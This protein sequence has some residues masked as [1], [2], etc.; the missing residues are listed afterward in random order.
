MRAA[1]G[2]ARARE[3]YGISSFTSVPYSG[4]ALSMHQRALCNAAFFFFR[5]KRAPSLRP[6]QLRCSFSAAVFRKPDDHGGEPYSSARIDALAASAFE[7]RHTRFTPAGA[8]RPDHWI[9]RPEARLRAHAHFCGTE[10]RC[11]FPGASE[12]YCA[13]Q[14]APPPSAASRQ[15]GCS[16]FAPALITRCLRPAHCGWQTASGQRLGS[17]LINP[18]HI[19]PVS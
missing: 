15:S 19:R 13:S 3:R 18:V 12:T 2:R 14:A 17:A 7:I 4:N 1:A 5:R 6:T 16:T 9:R 8:L 10:I 11:R